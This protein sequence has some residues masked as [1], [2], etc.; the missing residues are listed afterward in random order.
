MRCNDAWGGYSTACNHFKTQKFHSL[1]WP[2]YL[3]NDFHIFCWAQCRA[4]I[5]NPWVWLQMWGSISWYPK[6]TKDAQRNNSTLNKLG[7]YM[8]STDTCV[9]PD[10]YLLWA[11]SQARKYD[12]DTEKL[13]IKARSKSVWSGRHDAAGT[14][15]NIGAHV[16]INQNAREYRD[17]QT[18]VNF[19]D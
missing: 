4:K 6:V 18:R 15:D 10:G 1:P 5:T 17:V 13:F 11:V 12:T 8:W 19:T 9:A 14:N 16:R 2:E 3:R 7:Q